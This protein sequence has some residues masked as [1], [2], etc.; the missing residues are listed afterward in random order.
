MIVRGL[1][2]VFA[3]VGK[4]RSDGREYPDPTPVEIPANAKRPESLQEMIARMVVAHDFKR[5]IMERGAETLEEASDFEIE[6]DDPEEQFTRHEQMAVDIQENEYVR[7]AKSRVERA[8][9]ER[10]RDGRDRDEERGR[11]GRDGKEDADREREHRRDMQ[12]D[13]R[14][15]R[16]RDR[17]S[18]DEDAGERRGSGRIAEDR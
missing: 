6:G 15:H 13:G 10:G 8:R 4:F 11:G 7:E 1:Q 9:A 16:S 12:G 17:I 3:A 2:R 5:A 18:E 14:S